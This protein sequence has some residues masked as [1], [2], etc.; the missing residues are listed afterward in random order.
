MLQLNEC[1]GLQ[2]TLRYYRLN[3]EQHW[4]T[5]YKGTKFFLDEQIG[6][7]IDPFCS[8][9]HSALHNIQITPLFR[10]FNPERSDKTPVIVFNEQKSLNQNIMTSQKPRLLT[11]PVIAGPI[12][13]LFTL[14][15]VVFV[16]CDDDDDNQPTQNIV[17]L[18]QENDDLST[19]EAALVKFPDLVTTL[20]GNGTFTVF[21]PTNQA[22]QNLLTAIGQTSLDDVPEDVLRDILE[23][24]VL[25]TTVR[26]NQLVNGEVTTVGGEKATVNLS[27]GVKINNA[28]VTTEDV[29]ATNG[30]VHVID[31]VLV[32]PSI[33]PIVGTI[34]APAYF[35]KNFSTLIAAVKA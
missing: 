33:T 16:S 30:V 8:G 20:S 3:Q 34:V 4:L 26:S 11:R 13:F 18:A 1:G 25:T 29:A 15:A 14:L 10:Q 12:V 17:A 28:T 22:F 31:A 21:A 2:R 19:L 6:L 5:L 23:Y 9:I 27:S 24:H 35:N 7:S 32:P